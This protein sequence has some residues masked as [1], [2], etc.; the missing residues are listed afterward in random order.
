ME[1]DPAAGLHAKI[2][3]GSVRPIHILGVQVGDVALRAAQVP[4]QFVIGVKFRVLL[5]GE[6]GLVFHPGDGAFGIAFD[7]R[8]LAFGNDRSA[9]P[10][11]VE[12]EIMNP[13][14]EDIGGNGSLIERLQ[15]MFGLGFYPGQ[16]NEGSKRR[17]F[18]GR[19][20]AFQGI[21]R[22]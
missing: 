22:F 6:N 4:E 11:H 16:I 19:V 1:H 7:F 20:P 18:D 3:D 9:D 8:P 21:A 12:G 13:P 2:S 17:V 5:R 15:E 10:I 14:E